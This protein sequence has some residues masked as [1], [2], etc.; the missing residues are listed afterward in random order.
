MHD[1]TTD[2]KGRGSHGRGAVLLALLALIAC[3]LAPGAA[4]AFNPPTGN[5]DSYTV[6][7]GGTLTVNAPG[8]L[9]NDSDP[10]GQPISVI[11]V[12]TM[13]ANGSLTFGAD[14]SFTY[15]HNGSGSTSDSFV[16]VLADNDAG[17]PNVN[18]T[19]SLSIQDTAE[20]SVTL[21]DAPDPA[22]AGTDITYTITAANAG[23]GSAPSA[24]I[25]D[26]LP[27]DTV[28]RSLSA[29]GGW[30]CT[31]PAVGASGT[32]SCTTASFPPGSAVF[33]L[34]AEVA[35]A[36]ADGTVIS[37][38]ATI[39]SAAFD[40]MPG[41]DSATATTL[42]NS[43]AD[44]G[45]TLSG[46]PDPVAPGGD[47]TYS[48]SAGNQGPLTAAATL[49]DTLPPGM[50]FISLTVPA[51][52]SCTTPAVGANG[53]ITCT[54]AAFAASATH[55]LT[56]VARTD[57]SMPAGSSLVNSVAISS[58]S[59]DPNV[60]DNV[61]N[62][63]VTLGQGASTVSIGS[64]ANPSAA[65]SPVTFTAVV[66]PVA[67][68]TATPTGT[69]V[70]S[71]D[72]VPQAPAAVAAG[73][74]SLTTSA[75]AAGSHSISA[76][77][78]GDGNL[79]PS[80]SAPLTQNVAAAGALTLAID[81]APGHFLAAGQVISVRY[82]VANTGAVPVSGIA[83]SDTRAGSATCPT[84]S[85]NA[86]E[87]MTC[88][89]SHTV[90]DAD[91]AA[92]SILFSASV[93]G[94]SLVMDT[95][96]ATIAS[97][98]EA[99]R[100]LFGTMTETFVRKRSALLAAGIELPGLHGRRA[101]PGTI[102]L[103]E[104]SDGP[105]LNFAASTRSGAAGAAEGLAAG[106]TDV[107][108]N[109]WI[110]GSLALH[111]RT[112]AEGE[113]ALL[114]LGGD[115]RLGEELLVG[116][117]LYT[118]WMRDISAAGS[119]AGRGFLLGPYVSIGLGEGMTL[120]ASLLYGRSWNDARATAFGQELTGAFETDRFIAQVKLGGEW[121]VDA[122]TVRPDATV[123]LSHEA[124]SDYVVSDAFGNAVAVAGTTTQ[125][126]R[127]S[128]GVALEQTF[129]LG[130]QLSL[131]PE[132]G[133]RGGIADPLSPT[134]FASAFGS[135]SGGASLAGGAWTLRGV[136]ESQFDTDGF[137]AIGIRGSLGGSF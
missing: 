126:V 77:Y 70:F 116:V 57:P 108:Y 135:V 133:L 26:A 71:I 111:W 58:A 27:A 17:T 7:R 25:T 103:A 125:Q 68:A 31:V 36:T 84:T 45:V 109:F 79:T 3:L 83:V 63:S 128:A 122:L 41:D 121:L 69:V 92:G 97:G 23:P 87:T 110:D 1:R 123:F 48:I 61:A 136:V 134:P 96:T 32:V 46:G 106:G 100:D 119:V 11:S 73:V 94:N 127:L 19:V 44:L 72:G 29:P 104:G 49:T 112:G 52:W 9:A 124:A 95:A 102:V 42:V 38:T 67:P 43:G 82:R 66:A 54:I 50:G 6:G 114:G 98:A 90:T 99:V 137:G 118:D 117:A 22:D 81:F 15:I 4:L 131:T 89:A 88:V 91:M 130:D 30:S 115:Y 40:S 13:P 12:F 18:V 55:T 5:A 64:S 132:M 74:A 2:L 60:A 105:V 14:G 113:F 21:T 24:Q 62:L 120:D 107:P 37:N 20:L 80:V 34:V 101:G 59:S 10:D 76:A 65:G 39:S 78:S 93:S 35:A 129:A 33:T 86:G 8:V 85:L 53:T 75:L 47:V 51:G 28:F 16:Y 56:L